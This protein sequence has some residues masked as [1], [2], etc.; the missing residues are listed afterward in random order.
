MPQCLPKDDPNRVWPF[1]PSVVPS[2]L[3]AVLFGI[4]TVAHFVQA[5]VHRKMYC[6]VIV[7][8]SLWQT[9]TYALREYSVYNQ[10]NVGVYSLWFVMILVG[11]LWINAFVYMVVARLV[12]CF[13][14][15]KRLGGVRAWRFG[16]IFVLLDILAFLV[17]VAGASMASGNN[18]TYD[19]IMRGLHIY[20]GGVG[21]QQ[22]F[23]LAFT[24]LLIRFQLRYK[25]EN[26]HPTSAAP[27]RLLYVLYAVLT[28]IT[29]R[30]IFRLVEYSSGY[31]S[32]IPTHEAYTF[33][34]E[35]LPM[36]VAVLLL[37]LVHPGRVMPGKENNIPS[38]KV[39]KQMVEEGLLP[40]RRGKGS[41]KSLRGSSSD[42]ELAWSQTRPMP[43]ASHHVPE[44]GVVDSYESYRHA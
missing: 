10:K 30:I 34:L 12:W 36:F 5:I 19:Q 41:R 1:C 31:E 29:V 2:A 44:S 3:F 27:M 17:Q 18:L 40:G 4:L 15:N 35:S 8:A 42:T 23:I 11:P 16:T 9:A 14:P 32:G 33:V 38:K 6:W 37:N 43:S 26:P 20:M 25:R 7:V 21:L 39:R 28:L 22:F 24:G 13:M